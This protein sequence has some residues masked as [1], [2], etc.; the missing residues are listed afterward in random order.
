MVSTNGNA[1]LL[2]AESVARVLGATGFTPLRQV[3][4][5]A[6]QGAITL[7][8][9]VPS[10]FLKQLAQAAARGVAGVVAVRN[11]LDVAHPPARDHVSPA[12]ANG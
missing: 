9:R 5:A 10:F 2:L 1:D 11:H 3:T 6:G 7:R 4:V 8:G 12:A